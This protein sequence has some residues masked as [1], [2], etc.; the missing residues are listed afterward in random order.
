[1]EF[2]GNGARHHL[3]ERLNFGLPSELLITLTETVNRPA[4]TSLARCEVMKFHDFA[5]HD[6]RVWGTPA[7]PK[8]LQAF[9][10]PLKSRANLAG[11]RRL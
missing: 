10:V 1:L 3:L 2:H 8:L 5:M 7:G 9:S 4:N 11:G 6:R